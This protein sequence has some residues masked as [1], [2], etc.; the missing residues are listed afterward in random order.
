MA[1]K[2][3]SVILEEYESVDRRGGAETKN[4]GGGGRSEEAE[5]RDRERGKTRRIRETDI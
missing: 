2:P 5:E 1:T 3:R 4:N